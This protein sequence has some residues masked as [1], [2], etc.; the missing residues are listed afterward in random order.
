M[1]KLRITNALLL[2]LLLAAAGAAQ[3][4]AR[5]TTGGVKG[6]VKVDA[7]HTAGGVR[8]EAQRGE[9]EVARAVTDAK[10]NYELSNLAPGIYTLTFRKAGLKTAQHREVEVSAGKVRSLGDKVFL[11]VD[12]GSIAFV[13]GSV[14]DS[15]GRSVHGAQVEIARVGAD[16]AAR[17]LDGRVTSEAGTFSFRLSPDAARYRVTAKANGR[18][19]TKE[20]EVEGAMVYRVAL[21]LKPNEP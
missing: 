10:G 18:A 16:G 15:D 9:E 12:E 13:R 1:N 3:K 11:P 5:P 20:V 14:F 19:A 8:V 21:S 17:K 7:G 6:K 4:G 2:A